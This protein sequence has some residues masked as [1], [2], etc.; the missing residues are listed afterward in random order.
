[1]LATGAVANWLAGIVAQQTTESQDQRNGDSPRIS[2][3]SPRWGW[4]L[5]CVTVIVI[6]AF[7][8]ACSVGKRRAATGELPG[9]ARSAVGGTNPSSGRRGATGEFPSW[10]RSAPCIVYSGGYSG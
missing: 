10:R 6:L 8:A 3:S 9:G 4:T 1:M 7:A 5:G 2:I